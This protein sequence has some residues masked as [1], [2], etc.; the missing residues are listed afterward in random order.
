MTL[1]DSAQ[2]AFDLNVGT[3]LDH[4][5]AEFALREI[6]ANALD[7]Q[8]LTQTQDPTI[9][10][11]DRGWWH[12]R[13][14]GRGIRHVHL[15]Q[16][17]SPEKQQDDRVIG[18][19]G[20]GLKDALALFDR[21]GVTVAIRSK[22]GDIQLARKPKASFN[23]VVTLHALVSPPSDPSMIGTDFAMYG[24]AV[25]QVSAAKELFLAYRPVEILEETTVGQVLARPDDEPGSIFVR[26][27]LVATEDNF[28]FSYNITSLNTALKRALNRERS[29]VGRTAY[30]DR[31]KRILLDSTSEAVAGPLARDLAGFSTGDLHDEVA[32]TEVAL[33]ATRIMQST[34]KVLFVSTSDFESNAAEL[35]H[36][37]AD[38]YELVHVPEKI[39]GRLSDMSDLD[40]EPMVNLGRYTTEWNDSFQYTFVESSDLTAAERAV[41]ETAGSLFDLLEAPRPSRGLVKALKVT[42]TMRIGQVGFDA[43]GVWDPSERTII[44]ARHQLKTRAGFAGT[45]L[46]EICHVRSGSTDLTIAFENDLSAALGEIAVRA[47]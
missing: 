25:E 3:V 35:E 24:L 29:N 12:V 33:Q 1:T 14:Y 22:H 36:A 26:G 40:G 8:A 46:H 32:W 19:F 34:S 41:L 28:L 15:T 44:I 39:S 9:S 11:D 42:E 30:S 37:R 16:D 17:E 21:I 13:D 47:M 18:Q 7:E 6:I 45:L 31:V 4:W 2:R 23:D 38:G 20:M 10:Q 27:L 43:D 5:T